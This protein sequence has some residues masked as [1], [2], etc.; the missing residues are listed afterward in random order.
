VTTGGSKAIDEELPL[1][2]AAGITV[3]VRFSALKQGVLGSP[4][5]EFCLKHIMSQNSAGTYETFSQFD[6]IPFG[7]ASTD[8]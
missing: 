1:M 6:V 3:G 5:V 7:T 8:G 2:P 4:F